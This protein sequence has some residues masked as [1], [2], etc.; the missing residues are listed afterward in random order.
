MRMVITCRFPQY[1]EQ[2]EE[3]RMSAIEW[4]WSYWY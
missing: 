1:F 2:M 4:T 3:S